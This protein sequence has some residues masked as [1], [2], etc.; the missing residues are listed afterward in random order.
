LVKVL[1]FGL[2]KLAERP[3]GTEQDETQTQ[4]RETEGGMIL[5]TVSYMSPEQTEGKRLDAR[6]DIFAFGSILY[7]MLT[8]QK[9]FQGDSKL[10]IM[11]AILRDEPRPANQIGRDLSQETERI[12][13]RCLRKDPVRRFQT[14]ADLKVVL[15]EL[16][17]ES[18]SNPA[19]ESHKP[20]WDGRWKQNFGPL[21]LV[22][23]AAACAIVWFLNRPSTMPRLPLT[24]V[25]LTSDPGVE[26]FATFSPDGNQVA[27]LSDGGKGDWHLCITQIGTGT[28]LRRSNHADMAPAWSPDGRFI[29]ALRRQSSDKTALVLIPA[30]NG[31]E[32]QLAEIY[33][34]LP[35]AAD[36]ALVGLSWLPNGRWL[37]TSSKGSASEP[38]ALFL[39][40]AETGEKRRL[41]FPP[42]DSYGDFWPSV[43]PDGLSV[44]FTRSLGTGESDHVYVLRLSQNQAPAGEPNQLTFGDQ[45]DTSPVWTASGKEIIFSRRFKH[46]EDALWRVEVSGSRPPQPLPV[47]GRAGLPQAISRQGNRLVY[48]SFTSADI[49]IWQLEVPTKRLRKLMSSTRTD[50]EARFSPD[51]KRIGS[52]SYRTGAAE[53]WVSDS[54][55]ANPVQLTF[56]NGPQIDG[57]SWSRDGKRIGF[58]ATSQGKTT[59]YL[60]GVPDG[61]VEELAIAPVKNGFLSW[62]RDGR[63]VYFASDRSGRRE[64]WKMLAVGGDLAQVTRDGGFAAVE[65]RDGKSLYFLRG[66]SESA[67]LW[68]IPT[69]GGQASKVLE[70]V[71]QLNFAVGSDTIYFIPQADEKGQF[72]IQLFSVTTGKTKPVLRLPQE[73]LLQYGVDVS[74]DERWI[75]CT[76][77]SGYGE[78]D[79]MLAENFE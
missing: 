41:T 15:E 78:T 20:K 66:N 32:R 26:W 39:V 24:V 63:W 14:M 22:L 31:P 55:G 1:D 13:S 51:G 34:P 37:V 7:E 45:L 72:S 61:K 16:S 54:E 50:S 35:T 68:S 73:H 23:L 11:T 3:K 69:E 33:L 60:V 44:A 29:A 47:P 25:P 67:S 4:H 6:S 9:A 71:Y 75:L 48:V 5:G 49:D 74:P 40:S 18:E 27:Y 43:S 36:G 21:V 42:A 59:I 58:T 65:S 56:M 64:V 12:I 62:S 70:S 57:L 28:P 79:L 30:L 52:V 53:I 19:E 8:G 17:N 38:I 76:L 2:A 77:G 46:S 10:S